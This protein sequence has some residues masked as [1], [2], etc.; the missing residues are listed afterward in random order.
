[1]ESSPKPNLETFCFAPKPASNNALAQNYKS[2]DLVSNFLILNFSQTHKKVWE[3]YINFSGI[4]INEYDQTR[5]LIQKVIPKLKE[6]FF[7]FKIAGNNFFSMN[8]V[9][10]DVTYEFEHLDHPV[11][12]T[13][14]RS[15]HNIDLAKVTTDKK[16][17]K[18][19]KSFFENL[20]KNMMRANKNMVRLNRTNY[21]NLQ[22]MEEITR[23]AFL[24]NGFSTSFRHTDSGFM[25]LVNVKNKFLNG[26]N[27]YEKIKEIER[28]V[29]RGHEFISHLE[30]FFTGL[31]VMT[32]YGAPRVYQL[33][34]IN[35]DY[36][37]NNRYIRM[38]RSGE[39]ISL[40][41]YY[42]L[43]YPELRIRNENQPLLVVE[44]KK[45]DNTTEEIFLIPELCSL[46]GIDEK[47]G[48]EI[49]QSMTKRTKVR[50]MEKMRKIEEFINLLNN[51]DKRKK[52]TKVD[53][54]YREYS[55][56]QNIKEEWGL[57]ENGFKL[58]KGKVIP[59][60]MVEFKDG[61]KLWF[62][63]YSYNSSYY[64]LYFTFFFNKNL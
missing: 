10:Q 44:Q 21:F 48:N 28:E 27:C 31:T 43:N 61:S 40:K 36:N 12:A 25:L 14:K 56:A 51:K 16:I 34:G 19:I 22:N 4:E 39:E 20:L 24:V 3:Y 47:T 50:P 59:Y 60:P 53:D 37:I 1:M 26:M 2:I 7:P 5:L 38:H 9:E 45:S 6:I 11:V 13:I 46:T 15:S 58:L 18:D 54:S 55:S 30:E 29:G 23:N 62:I 63:N 57:S 32:K 17:E 64:I 41:R 35:V 33:K 42:E 52:G 49:K 8:F